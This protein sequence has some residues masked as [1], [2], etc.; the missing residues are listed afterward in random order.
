MPVP[1]QTSPPATPRRVDPRVVRR[2][3]ALCA[4]VAVILVGS[5]LIPLPSVGHVRSWGSSLGPWFAWMFFIA[6][7][8]VTIA[9][10]PR[11]A[12]TVMSGVLFGPLVGFVGAMIASTAAAVAAFVLVRA[13]G[14]DRVRPYL[15]KPVV[16]A[17]DY[18]LERRGW[19]AVGSL[20]LIAACPFSVANY[21][22]GLSS[23]RAWPYALASVA[24][25]APG[26]AAVVFLGNALTGQRDPLMLLVSGG[27]FAVGIIGLLVDARLP[28]AERTVSSPQS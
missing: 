6:Y 23:V 24:G 17:I 9:P 19:L 12:F 7:A 16:Q 4:V 21:C 14:R 3:V 13:M 20:R 11:S 5:Y 10:F 25:M 28:V 15:K 1:V 8:L 26:T 22:S 27:L 18:R 2:A